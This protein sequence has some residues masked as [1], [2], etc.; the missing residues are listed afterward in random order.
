[1]NAYRNEGKNGAFRKVMKTSRSRR[2]L[3]VRGPAARGR[4]GGRAGCRDPIRRRFSPSYLAADTQEAGRPGC[5]GR[6]R[7]ERGSL[8]LS[9][10][11]EAGA[12]VPSL[13]SC[14]C[15]SGAAPCLVA[16]RR[17]TC[18]SG[19]EPQ[20]SPRGPVAGQ[21]PRGA[22]R[23]L[24]GTPCPPS[25]PG[26]FSRAPSPPTPWAAFLLGSSR[27]C[28]SSPPLTVPARIRFAASRCSPAPGLG[29]PTLDSWRKCPR[30]PGREAIGGD[31]DSK[32]GRES[33][34]TSH[35]SSGAHRSALPPRC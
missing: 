27:A 28:S 2:G 32:A 35:F 23:C 26:S 33:L 19:T 20:G 24:L 8:L 7:R 25:I 18:R 12:G 29:R 10:A 15:R 13:A 34:A 9:P 22:Q 17:W 4:C 11:A 31:G 16:Q 1:M 6:P 3:A 5:A 30:I 14:C 21:Y